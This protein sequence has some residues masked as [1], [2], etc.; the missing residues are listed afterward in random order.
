MTLRAS[1]VYSVLLAAITPVQKTAWAQAGSAAEL[2]AVLVTPS[3]EVQAL[4]EAYAK[5][6]AAPG[7]I[8]VIPI[9]SYSDGTVLGMSDALSR[10]P[11]V[12]TQNPSGQISARISIRGSGI[13]SPSG[14]RGVRLLR[15]GLPLGRT[16]DV[17]DSIYTDPLA[18]DF[19][20]VLRGANAMQYGVAT[21]GGAVNL[22][23][24]TGYTRSG[25]RA[26]LEGGAYGYKSGR[27]EGGWTGTDGW[28]AYASVSSTRSDGYRAHSDYKLSRFYGN[29]GY[30]FSD[31]S[32]GR[33]HVTQEYYRVT[34]PG[35]LTYDQL[36]DDPQQANAASEM[37]DAHIR[38]TPR[39]HL[40]YVHD[41]ALSPD[42]TL[43]VGLFHTG[44]KFSSW[45]TASQI[46]YDAIDYGMSLRQE[47]KSHWAG[48][49]NRIVWGG[50]YSR[51]DDHNRSY[52]PDMSSVSPFAPPEGSP[53]AD[54]DTSRSQA[55][56][57]F[58]N[59]YA[60]TP[61]LTWVAGAQ[62]VWAQRSTDNEVSPL[63][64]SFFANGQ[65]TA[66]Y[67]GFS[68]KLG[69]VWNST[70]TTQ[71][72]ANL[73]RSFEPPSAVAFFSPDG[74]LDA[75]RA[76]TFEIGTRGGT[77]ALRW[78]VALYHAK[79]RDELIETYLPGNV[80]ITVAHNAP[81]TIHQGLEA[82]LKGEVNL[83]TVPGRLEWALAY[84]FNDFRF[85]D[86]SVYGNNALPGIP[87]HVGRL[88]LIYRHPQ[89]YYAGPG[90][91]LG[92][93]WDVDQANTEQAPGYGLLH[94]RAGYDSPDE[95]FRLYIDMRNL[96]DKTYV[97]STDYVVDARKL[98]S[99]AL[100]TPGLGRSVFMGVELTY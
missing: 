72:Y 22:V 68:P 80:G 92:S 87:R 47:I 38:T 27:L 55:E 74:I 61:A 63:A 26:R 39:W 70:P 83:G 20:E 40:A 4:S 19:I 34:M 96:L 54:L 43:A 24:P 14:T 78:D 66:R 97:A 32:K 48:H 42:N 36:Q 100:Y 6:S 71:W 16:D 62:M 15:D 79:V 86:D 1:L 2:P 12:Y 84:T 52:W 69:L 44:T 17:G 23:S 82:G 5:R 10:T 64:R 67:K 76:T 3:A 57:F 59:H 31:V 60:L 65:A 29:V 21:L 49:D 37:V 18:A 46:N 93:G 95:R 28:D 41:I 73:S 77:D 25:F 58:E 91:E 81:R 51:G 45:G 30:Q 89:G 9:E 75:Q 85:S 8:S 98:A 33:L 50:S 94:F 7:H 11:G 56:L 53:Q 99:K 90:L 35:A 13:T 88:D